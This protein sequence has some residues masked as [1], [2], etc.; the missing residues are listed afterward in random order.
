[1][2]FWFTLI[3]CAAWINIS[4]AQ[5]AGQDGSECNNKLE[6]IMYR[7]VQDLASMMMDIKT[8]IMISSRQE[9]RMAEIETQIA[10][11]ETSVQTRME[12]METKLTN[13]TTEV[14]NLKT[15]VTNNVQTIMA[16]IGDQVTNVSAQ[17]VD[18]Q[19]TLLRLSTGNTI[20]QKYYKIN[21]RQHHKHNK[22]YTASLT[23]TGSK[24][25]FEQSA[26]SELYITYTHESK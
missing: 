25:S 19:T 26:R 20:I 21:V 13:I 16:N 12:N 18:A 4:Y 7:Q 11:I 22:T 24:S 10:N 2:G 3:V 9:E 14:G 8:V 5:S 6:Q 17:I 15:E 1:M 23:E